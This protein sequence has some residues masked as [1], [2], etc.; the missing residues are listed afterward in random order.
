MFAFVHKSFEEV[1]HLPE[2]ER[3]P[4]L[5]SL[6]D[7]YIAAM[8]GAELARKRFK[9]KRARRIRQKKRADTKLARKTLMWNQKEDDKE[10]KVQ[11]DLARE[12]REERGEQFSFKKFV[13]EWREARKKPLV[14]QDEE[15]FEKYLEEQKQKMFI[16]GPAIVRQP[17]S[18]RAGYARRFEVEITAPIIYELKRKAYVTKL[19]REREEAIKAKKVAE[20][21]ELKNI[22]RAAAKREK[23]AV[24]KAY[25]DKVFG[26]WHKE[27]N[28][29]IALKREYH[30]A[31]E[32][33]LAEARKEF[34]TAMNQDVSMWEESP[35]ECKF[36]RFQLGQ[37][38]LFPFN[39][40][41]YL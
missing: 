22:A 38:V 31:R 11:R 33:V 30:L 12:L 16:K 23:S 8:W 28:R 20:E 39:N 37:G 9:A 40:T 10:Y 15:T 24:R 27:N 3:I 18:P 21:Q 35:D 32:G 17:L 41:L 5:Q 14:I 4:S 2:G 34:L 19:V 29:L 1:R 26:E 7:D 6:L 25:W 36:Q 13:K